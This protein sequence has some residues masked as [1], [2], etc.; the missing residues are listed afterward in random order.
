MGN[1]N[2]VVISGRLTRDPDLRALPSG[3]QIL[4]LSVAVNDRR[5]NPSTGDWEDYANFIDCS[6]FG[7]RAESLSRILH[8][9]QLVCIEGKLRYSAWERDGVKRSKIE[10][11]ID[12]IEIPQS[13]A[14]KSQGQPSQRSQE[15]EYDGYEYE[16]I[17]F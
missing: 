10:V 2:K 8:K 1:I 9:G 15:T 6:M 3:K 4:G 17:P 16:P 7:N 13:D 11:V 12:E 14:H 5:K